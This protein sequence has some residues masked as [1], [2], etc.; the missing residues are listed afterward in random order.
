V[1]QDALDKAQVGRT[2]IVIA[3]RSVYLSYSSFFLTVGLIIHYL[4]LSRLSTIQNSH[5]ISVV[6]AGVVVEEGTHEELLE[7]QGNYYQLQN[8]NKSNLT[9]NTDPYDN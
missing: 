2:C 6:K 3:H 7:L 8:Q 4:I 9:S 1:V 5:K